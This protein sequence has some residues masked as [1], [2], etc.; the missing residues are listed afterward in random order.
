MNNEHSEE[1]IFTP[2]SRIRALDWYFSID[3]YTLRQAIQR[4]TVKIHLKDVSHYY[5]SWTGYIL[6][7][8]RPHE[9]ESSLWFPNP[10]EANIQLK[11][12]SLWKELLSPFFI[13][14]ASP[15][16]GGVIL[17]SILLIA[18]NGQY[19]KINR[20]L[21]CTALEHHWISGLT[22]NAIF[23][24]FAIMNINASLI[25][26]FI[27]FPLTT[28]KYWSNAF[29]GRYYKACKLLVVFLLI[30]SI[31]AFSRAPSFRELTWAG[32]RDAIQIYK[33]LL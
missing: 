22:C 32:I 9:R 19:R 24:Q 14:L 21:A 23:R 13:S 2:S 29:E 27:V 8:R 15:F 26:G 3:R 1:L 7:F 5:K 33:Y 31:D 11:K 6:V 4:A 18:G 20:E 25:L 28:V 17:S 30:L 12:I 16:T 10:P